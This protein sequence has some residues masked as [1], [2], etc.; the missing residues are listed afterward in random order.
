MKLHCTVKM[1]NYIENEKYSQ[2]NRIVELQI[3]EIIGAVMEK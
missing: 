1:N 2:Y 3:V